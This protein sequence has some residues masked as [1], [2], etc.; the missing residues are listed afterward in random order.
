MFTNITILVY[1][2]FFSQPVDNVDNPVNNSYNWVSLFEL[3]TQLF[4]YK[5]WKHTTIFTQKLCV[6]I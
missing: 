1:K 4:V 6:L 5:L 3:F 2:I